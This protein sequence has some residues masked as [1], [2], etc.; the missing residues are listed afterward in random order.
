MKGRTDG[1][2]DGNGDDV[3]DYDDGDGVVVYDDHDLI[4]LLLI[5][6]TFL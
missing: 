5:S 4:L 3:D 6:C 2:D 1:D